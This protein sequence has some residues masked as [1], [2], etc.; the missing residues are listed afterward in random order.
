MHIDMD[1]FEWNNYSA[2]T[3]A[4]SHLSLGPDEFRLVLQ[5]FTSLL[6]KNRATND[7][8][9]YFYP[10]SLEELR[11]IHVPEQLVHNLEGYVYEYRHYQEQN[12]R[13]ERCLFQLLRWSSRY[14]S[15]QVAGIT[16]AIFKEAELSNPKFCPLY[17][18][19]VS[20]VTLVDGAFAELIRLLEEYSYEA[21]LAKRQE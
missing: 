13:Q 6:P 20:T 7:S 2:L 5:F 21:F 4:Q 8:A 1:M 12:A 17:T 16:C 3:S 9:E 15:N 14:G 10:L 19:G 11:T 18:F